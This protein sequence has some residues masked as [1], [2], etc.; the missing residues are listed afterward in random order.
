MKKKKREE[1]YNQNENEDKINSGSESDLKKKDR[2]QIINDIVSEKSENDNKSSLNL[3][4]DE[5]RNL[6]IVNSEEIKILKND[7]LNKGKGSL[8]SKFKINEANSKLEKKI[9][10]E[11]VL[12][13]ANYE[14]NI[15]YKKFKSEEERINVYENLNKNEEDFFIKY[16]KDKIKN[17]QPFR[18]LVELS[19]K[20]KFN[21][22]EVIINSIGKNDQFSV[23]IFISDFYFYGDGLAQSKKEGKSK[24]I[25]II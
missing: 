25:E 5:Q 7:L 12:D 17:D 22:P 24:S 20:C 23:K 6:S 14:K 18:I 19:Q 3:S 21:T 15:N 10:L 8:K 2:K 9:E 1:S 11:P 13:N 4:L 16:L